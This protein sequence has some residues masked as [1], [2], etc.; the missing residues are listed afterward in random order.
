MKRSIPSCCDHGLGNCGLLKREC[1]RFSLRRRH[2]CSSDLIA[3]WIRCSSRNGLSGLVIARNRKLRLFEGVLSLFSVTKEHS[4][5]AFRGPHSTKASSWAIRAISDN[6][7][8]LDNAEQLDPTIMEATTSAHSSAC[9]ALIAG[10]EQFQVGFVAKIRTDLCLLLV[11]SNLYQLHLRGY[12]IPN[13][14]SQCTSNI[15][16]ELL[17]VCRILT[18]FWITVKSNYQRRVE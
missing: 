7:I 3:A 13:F 11:N 12:K 10:Y 4:A 14:P 2:Y 17:M 18:V 5:K 8:V 16:Q 6:L 9:S 1:A 15:G